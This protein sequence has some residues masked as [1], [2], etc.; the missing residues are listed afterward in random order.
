MK[1]VVATRRSLTEVLQRSSGRLAVLQGAGSYVAL[2]AV[3]LMAAIVSPSFYQPDNL[4][5]ILRQ[6]S[7]LGVLSV[8][9][10]VV[11]IGG[12][13]DLSV[14]ATMQLS[15]V[16]LA[17]MTQGDNSRVVPALLLCLALGGL[18][19]WVNGVIITKRSLPPFIVTLA[20]GIA[21]TGARLAY[22]K[23]SPSGSLPPIV[24]SLGGGNIGMVPIATLTFVLFAVLIHLLL[25]RTT[26]GR[27]LYSTGS[28]RKAA[29]L[30]GVKVDR[31]S[32]WTYVVCGWLAVI[33]GLIL[34]GWVGYADQ[35][36]GKGMEM[37]SIAA[38]VLGGA[39]FAG[40]VGDV[41]GTI[42]GV[43]LIT[44]LLNL[45]LLLN[46]DVQYQLVVKGAV[47]LLAVALYNFRWRS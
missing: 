28:N 37:D 43:L 31:I 22:T 4:F 7:A 33:S 29:R 47:L 27:R 30:S 35:W 24:K 26:F 6:A 23:A 25:T 14:A 12:G 5:N 1:A 36:I 17:Q 16:L 32:I 19:G 34:A 13:I 18:I 45:V 20:M 9:Q 46:L 38:V 15:V 42:A 41:K 11:I 44:I 40:G 3:L 21:V 39:S 2:L 10:T 8:A